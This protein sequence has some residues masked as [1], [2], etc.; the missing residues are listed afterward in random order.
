VIIR[1]GRPGFS[2]A[3]VLFDR[4]GTDSS[5]SSRISAVFGRA[6]R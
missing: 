3:A 4:T 2:N 5:F 6:A 1:A